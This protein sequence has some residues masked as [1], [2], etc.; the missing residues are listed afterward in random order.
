M[1]NNIDLSTIPL[2]H[3][4]GTV[5][6]PCTIAAINLQLTG[7]LT[8]GDPTGCMSVIV[9]RWTIRVQDLMPAEMLTPDDEHGRRWREVAPMIAGSKHNGPPNEQRAAILLDWMWGCLG[10]EWETWVPSEV[11]DAWRRLL[12]ERTV[13]CAYAAYDCHYANA[14]DANDAIAQAA[15]NAGFAVETFRHSPSY[16]HR[17]DDHTYFAHY[18]AP[19]YVARSVS[20]AANAAANAAKA[21]ANVA[22]DKSLAS[23]CEDVVQVL[24]SMNVPG[25]QWLAL[26]EAPKA[27]A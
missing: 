25:V 9:R 1:T 24:I 23:F 2:A 8:G 21:A 16:N 12:E 18:A 14:G 5:D 20:A 4:L 3:G 10:W 15:V 22:R 6:E 17:Y 11:H 13:G 19:S 7:E 27:A 26:T